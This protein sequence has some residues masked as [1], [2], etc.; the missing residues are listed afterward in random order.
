M[1]SV[2]EP[3][4]SPEAVP[5]RGMAYFAEALNGLMRN[6]GVS[7]RQ[8][9]LKSHFSAR[10]INSWCNGKGAPP[11]TRE[12]VVLDSILDSAIGLALIVRELR[13]RRVRNPQ[14]RRFWKVYT[15]AEYAALE[16]QTSKS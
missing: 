11:T 5:T 4:D 7:Q 13:K 15:L 8:L 1:Q 14:A 3:K 2:L 16:T 10:K 6:G 12:A 9:I